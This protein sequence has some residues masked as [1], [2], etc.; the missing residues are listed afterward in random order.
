MQRSLGLLFVL[1]ASIFF[2]TNA[3]A[4]ASPS[5]EYIRGYMAAILETQFEL[6]DAQIAVSAG[7]VTITV[8][9]SKNRQGLAQKIKTKGPVGVTAVAVNE[10]GNGSTDWF[11]EERLFRPLLADPRWPHFYASYQAYTKAE[12]LDS[13]GSVGFGENF[14]IIGGDLMGGRW[15]A[16]AQFGV[17]AIFDMDS[18]SHD[19]INADYR[20][21]IPVIYRHSDFSAIARIYHQSSHLGDEYL[22]RG[23][24]I[25]DNR[26]NLSY[27]A[28]SALLSYDYNDKLRFYG[29]GEY[30]FHQ[31]FDN[32]TKREDLNP[33]SIQIGGDY[34]GNALAQKFWRG[35]V[36]FVAGAD[37]RS[38]EEAD[39]DTDVSLRVGLDFSGKG[40]HEDDRSVRILLEYFDGR[41]PHGQFYD[42]EIEYVGIGAHLYY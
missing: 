41:S 42:E 5:D 11:P 29:G 12:E 32:D 19:L 1:F 25:Q 33:W 18:D 13:V 20:V 34:I 17:F 22:L 10:A 36:R 40:W 23:E 8:P 27:E 38:M 15:Q 37:F 6:P 4:T 35:D 3:V 24:D 7:K 2:T 26:E 16:G 31:S 30:I 9:Q 14:P 21:G 39:W 28:I